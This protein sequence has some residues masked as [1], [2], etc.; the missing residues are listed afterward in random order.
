VA[1]SR[2]LSPSKDY[3]LS[4]GDI[5]LKVPFIWL[6]QR[7]L[8]VLRY[9]GPWKGLEL[10]SLHKEEA[11]DTALTATLPPIPSGLGSFRWLEWNKPE[12]VAA[13][14]LFSMGMV[15]T[16]DC[17]CDNDDHR[18]LAMIR[19]IT[20]LDKDS[21]DDLLANERTD[22]FALLPQDESP[23]MELSFVDFRK[24]VMLR[25]HALESPSKRYASASPKLREELAGAYYQYLHH[26]PKEPRPP[27]HA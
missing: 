23:K 4:Q 6:D 9:Y 5:F 26:E 16:H 11:G 18:T 19:P 15:V 24:T 25:P 14:C 1:D 10:Y 2:Y 3:D 27:K 12:V 20:E 21:Q 7:P 13:K 17:E 22:L 8:V